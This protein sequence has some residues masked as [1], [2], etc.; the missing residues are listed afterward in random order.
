MVGHAPRGR[1]KL[2]LLLVC[3]VEPAGS[4][5]ATQASSQNRLLVNW[6][7]GVF[8]AQLKSFA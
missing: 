1:F 2:V 4:L 7:V 8:I 3:G 5:Q 6:S